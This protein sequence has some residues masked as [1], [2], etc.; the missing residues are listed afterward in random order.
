MDILILL[1]FTRINP[2]TSLF[3]QYKVWREVITE[4][5]SQFWLEYVKTINYNDVILKIFEHDPYF[6][7][8]IWCSS[9][10]ISVAWKQALLGVVK[11]RDR[12]LAGRLYF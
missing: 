7:R 12:E 5:S 11:I 6:W 4:F 3:E 8:R 1:L 9:Y 10:N 2:I